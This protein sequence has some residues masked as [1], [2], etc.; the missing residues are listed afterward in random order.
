M[1]KSIV[2]VIVLLLASIGSVNAATFSWTHSNPDNVE[3]YIVELRIGTQSDV[4]GR[5]LTANTSIDIDLSDF[6]NT[7]FFVKVA[8]YN[9]AGVSE[10]TPEIEFTT[11]GFTP[12][13]EIPLITP[14]FTSPD[15]PSEIQGQ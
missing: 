8:A 4:S 9:E 7:L 14:G 15:T 5:Y 1:K 3:G 6:Y 11:P 13:E 2:F 10:F 12:P